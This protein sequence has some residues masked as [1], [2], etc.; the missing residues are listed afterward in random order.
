MNPNELKQART[1]IGAALKQKRVQAKM[2][3]AGLSKKSGLSRSTIVSIETGANS[4][5]IDSLTIYENGLKTP[6]YG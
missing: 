2:T 4:Y 6:L 1:I 3:Q 5:N